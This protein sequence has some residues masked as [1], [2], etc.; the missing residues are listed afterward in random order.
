MNEITQE[1]N[2]WLL[3]IL[4]VS[5]LIILFA[6]AE[7]FIMAKSQEMFEAF[8]QVSPGGDFSSYID[9][10]LFHFMLNIIEPIIISLYTYFIIHKGGVTFTY[11]IFFG[12]ILIIRL[13]HL[14]LQ[15]RIQSLFYY[16]LIALFVL[17]FV[18]VV[19]VPYGKK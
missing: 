11:R 4:V 7:A 10:V 12:A 5:A 3:R 8:L 19:H 18:V 6:S 13:V 16:A 14:V 2:R 1:R 9:M 15:F 17:L